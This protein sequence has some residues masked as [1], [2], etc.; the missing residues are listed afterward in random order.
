MLKT[1]TFHLLWDD[2]R[3]HVLA[4]NLKVTYKLQKLK[5]NVFSGS[6]DTLLAAVALMY[7]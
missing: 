7:H 1:Q 6:H 5:I 4:L 3:W 2:V